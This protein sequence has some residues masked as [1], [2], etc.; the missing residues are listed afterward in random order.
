MTNERLIKI[1][2]ELV[3]ECI[4]AKEKFESGKLDLQKLT[5]VERRLTVERVIDLY[6]QLRYLNDVN[7]D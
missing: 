5:D 3:F 2:D 6:Y 1:L 4:K 7:F